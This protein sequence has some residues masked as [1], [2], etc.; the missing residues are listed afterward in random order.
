M[1]NL[2]FRRTRLYLQLSMLYRLLRK[3][4][5]LVSLKMKRFECLDRCCR[6][7]LLT[8]SSR[9]RWHQECGYSL[10]IIL[11]I[12]GKIECPFWEMDRVENSGTLKLWMPVFQNALNGFFLRMKQ[13]ENL[14]RIVLGII[15]VSHQ[16]QRQS[17]L[18]RQKGAPAE[19]NPLRSSFTTCG[20]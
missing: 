16:V 13:A 9:G 12:T 18:S 10:Q 8:L 11:S 14:F 5:L 3:W 19:P 15:N 4:I 7:I 1:S 6:I 20:S 17:W 2:L